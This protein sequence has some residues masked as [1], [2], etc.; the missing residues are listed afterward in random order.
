[1][2]KQ[3]RRQVNQWCI[4]RS[5]FLNSGFTLIEI[6]IVM[7]IVGLVSG[8]VGIMISRGG[9]TRELSIFTKKI[10]SVLRYARNRSVSEKKIYSF[11]IDK[12]EQAYRLYSEDTDYKNIET[13]MDEPIPEGLQMSLQNNDEESPH[14]EFS[15]RGNSTGGVIEIMNEP[16]K[17]VYININ[18]ITGKVDVEE[19]E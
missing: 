19:A 6:I 9:E 12:N 17:M 15:P 14:I 13:V 2:E 10:S 5:S 3:G 4:N 18:R 11:V 8:L 16:G 7:L 1:M